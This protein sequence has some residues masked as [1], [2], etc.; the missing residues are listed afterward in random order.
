MNQVVSCQI[1]LGPI[2]DE[3]LVLVSQT[4]G[5]SCGQPTDSNYLTYALEKDLKYP[6][7]SSPDHECIWYSVWPWGPGTITCHQ[8]SGTYGAC[9]A[10]AIWG[11]DTSILFDQGT[12]STCFEAFHLPKGVEGPFGCSVSTNHAKDILIGVIGADSSITVNPSGGGFSPVLTPCP[13]GG[14][15]AFEQCGEF[16]VVSATQNNT[17]FYWSWPPKSSAIDIGDIGIAV[18][19]HD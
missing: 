19:L 13:T 15:V 4:G 10:F 12:G 9:L 8:S 7:S 16:Q 5:S 1:T 17:Y 3:D 11:E 6:S 14:G 18:R 2:E